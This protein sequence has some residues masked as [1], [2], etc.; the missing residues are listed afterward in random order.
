MSFK[1]SFAT[2]AILGSALLFA[3]CADAPKEITTNP[4]PSAPSQTSAAPSESTAPASGTVPMRPSGGTSDVKWTAPSGWEVKPA[5]GMRAAT[6]IIPPAKGDTD[7]GECAVFVNIGGGVQPNIDRWIGQFEQPDG[8]ASAAKAKQ[9]KETINGFPVTTVD[10]TGT[11]A[12][13]GMAMG[14]APTKKPGYRLL[15]A[16]VEGP[17]GEVFFKLTGPAKTIAAAQNDFRAMLKSVKK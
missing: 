15:G 4:T 14:Q 16:I 17:S 2:S 5:S 7:G 8:S 12:G 1:R 9:G 10:L 11:F 13:G 3:A 6:Y